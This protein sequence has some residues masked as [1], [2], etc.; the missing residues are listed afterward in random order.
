MKTT[1]LYLALVAL[2]SSPASLVAESLGVSLPVALDWTHLL[3]DFI[4][5][6]VLLTAFAEYS[7]PAPRLSPPCTVGVPATKAA[8]ALA[9]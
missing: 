5:A 4:T 3:G 9:A 2:V 7:R 1:L 8:H 6:L